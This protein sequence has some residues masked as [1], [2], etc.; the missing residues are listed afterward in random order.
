MFTSHDANCIYR[1]LKLGLVIIESAGESDRAM[2]V[3]PA[4]LPGTEFRG[5]EGAN[6]ANSIAVG[7]YGTSLRSN[8]PAA[9]IQRCAKGWVVD[10]SSVAAPGPGAVWFHE[11]FTTAEDAVQAIEECYFG[12]R[13]D[14]NTAAQSSLEFKSHPYYDDSDALSNWMF[15]GWGDWDEMEEGPDKTLQGL[16]RSDKS[17]LCDLALGKIRS[18]AGEDYLAKT[19]YP[20]LGEFLFHPINNQQGY[21]VYIEWYFSERPGGNSNGDFWWTL[22][23]CPYAVPPFPTGRREVVVDGIGWAIS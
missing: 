17:M 11:E 23:L 14:N 5:W 6:L 20:E 22:I 10:I 16:L 8:A 3:R 18:L 21:R 2:I 19:P 9:W 7:T 12:S 13:I 4:S 15:L 1:L